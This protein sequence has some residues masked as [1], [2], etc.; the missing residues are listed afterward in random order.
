MGL[1]ARRIEVA[2]AAVAAL[3]PPTPEFPDTPASVGFGPR[4]SGFVDGL[5]GPER[6][7]VALFLSLLQWL[8]ISIGPHRRR[9]TKLS[10]EQASAFFGRLGD[11]KL[12][13][14][15]GAAKIALVLLLPAFYAD[16][17]LRARLGDQTQGRVAAQ[18]KTFP[19]ERG[20]EVEELLEA[21]VVIVGSGAGGAPLAKE[22]AEL[23]RSVIVLEE[24]GYR[25]A[26]T[27]PPLAF[28]ALSQLYRDS[29]VTVT[30]GVPPVMVPIGKL[31]GGTT[32]INSG[33][34]FRVPDFV[35]AKWVERYGMPE[36]LSEASLAPIY[37]RVED[38]IGVK[39]VTPALLGGNNDMARIG[40][41]AL[42]WSGGYLPR[43]FRGCVGSNRCA[44]GCPTDAKQA[45]HVT[46]LPSAVEAGARVICATRVEKVTFEGNRATGVVARVVEPGG[47]GRT[48]RV[49]ADAVVVAAGTFY[50]PGLLRASGVRHRNLGRRVTLHPAV[51]ISAHFPGKDFYDGPGVPQSYYVDEFQQQGVMMEGAHVPPDMG[52]VALPGKGPEHKRLM[53]VSRELSTFGFLVSDEPSGTV[54][55]G[56]G[57]RPFVR[58]DIGKADEAKMM[59]GLKKL[60]KLYVAAGATKLY[61]P[62]WRLP[63][64]DAG[65]N[66]EAQIDAAGIR[67]ADLEVAAFHPLGTCGFGPDG[68]T[69]PLDCD[70]R[71]R[72]RQGLYVADGSVMPSSLAVNPQLTIM[73]LATRLAWHLDQK[74]TA[75]V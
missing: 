29:G 43:N 41:E 56:L 18:A 67:A 22:L 30:V 66:V 55:R 68:D 49:K 74:L 28:D 53:E 42:G 70:L 20:G 16:E 5:P 63:E 9:L 7:G 57:D 31:V 15:R 44:F 65:P 33:T 45:M 2:C 27:F 69:F 23:G 50:T 1:S 14:L 47:K 59:L 51:K 25:P 36:A 19:V 39:P 37:Q 75:G 52:S 54:M 26:T 46:Y 72:G 34:C 73:V 17:S 61:L 38:I 48:L 64:L 40:A 21:D 60:A 10:A 8:P 3:A 6:F 24:G 13:P 11:S 62:T 58:Y 71:V 35:H 12:L 32:V 4:L